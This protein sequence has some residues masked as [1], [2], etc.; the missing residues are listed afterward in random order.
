M[1][2]HLRDTNPALIWLEERFK[3]TL[4]LANGQTIIV[5]FDIS[6]TGKPTSFFDAEKVIKHFGDAI[7]ADEE[8]EYGEYLSV[9][10]TI[11]DVLNQKMSQVGAEIAAHVALAHEVIT[12]IGNRDMTNACLVALHLTNALK[13][14]SPTSDTIW[15]IWLREVVTYTQGEIDGDSLGFGEN[16]LGLF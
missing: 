1:L 3:T 7:L 13:E 5:R 12:S 14:Y 8:K 2:S 11:A 16:T 6:T 10:S 4:S 9:A 15:A